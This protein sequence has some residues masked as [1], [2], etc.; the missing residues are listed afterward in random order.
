MKNRELTSG[1][2]YR[3]SYGSYLIWFTVLNATASVIL[4]AP[5]YNFSAAMVGVTYVSPL[6]GVVLG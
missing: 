6:I 2:C 1:P 4:G 3:F 5:P